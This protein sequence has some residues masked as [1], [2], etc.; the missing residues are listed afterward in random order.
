MTDALANYVA[1]EPS[2]I[3]L[4]LPTEADARD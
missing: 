4:L 3:M 2:P 1:N